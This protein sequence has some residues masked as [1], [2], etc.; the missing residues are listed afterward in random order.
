MANGLK[1]DITIYEGK[2]LDGRNRY[3]ACLAAG[4]T[5]TTY[6][7][8][9]DN[10]VE[11][12]LS[13]NLHRRHLTPSQLAAVATDMLPHLE[14]EAKKRQIRKPADSVVAIVPQQNEGMKARDQAAVA[15]G[16]SPRYVSDAK[17]LKKQS[18]ELHEEVL[19]GKTTL[20]AAMKKVKA[21]SAA[22][23]G[24]LKKCGPGGR[25]LSQ[26]RERTDIK[27]YAELKIT[28]LKRLD[29][30]FKAFSPKLRDS[31]IAILL[32]ELA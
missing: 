31:I 2:I 17:V 28:V 11:Y 3:R 15:V 6:Q 8:A 4:V 29:N 1:Q 27:E 32:E 13:L 21:K 7:Y 14:A 18:P 16:V 30:L 26:K 22:T 12:V 23:Y 10:P 20:P 24:T 5:P 25:P 19:T 9:G